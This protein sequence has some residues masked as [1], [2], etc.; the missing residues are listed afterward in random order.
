LHLVTAQEIE[1]LRNKLARG[2]VP[3]D[4][5]TKLKQLARG[6]LG[7]RFIAQHCQTMIAL[8]E[9]AQEGSFKEAGRAECERLLRVLAYVRK[10][11]DA[12]P[13]YRADGFV[14]DQ[15]EVRSVTAE[16]GPLLQRF[17]E[18]RLRH[19]VPAMWTPFLCAPPGQNPARMLAV[20]GR[21]SAHAC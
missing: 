2:S 18:W 3:A 13:D 15:Q 4:L 12:I 19:Q 5:E 17:K 16:L 7:H 6:E 8:V 20:R 21:P 9:A 11:D 14:D 10:D 1:D